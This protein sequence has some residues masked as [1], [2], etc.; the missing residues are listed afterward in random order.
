[1]FQLKYKTRKEKSVNVFFSEDN[2]AW[3]DYNDLGT[4]FG[5]SDDFIK[6]IIDELPDEEINDP[7]YEIKDIDKDK[8]YYN[9]YS[10][11]LIGGRI[12]LFET[13][14]LLRWYNFFTKEYSSDVSKEF[15]R[16]LYHMLGLEPD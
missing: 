2:N 7:D 4:L 9:L 14:D 10:V 15:I 5:V 13:A 16:N 12:N 3:I 8:K 11:V 1:M 6:E